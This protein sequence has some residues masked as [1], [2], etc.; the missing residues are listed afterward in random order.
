M[1]TV[2]ITHRALGPLGAAALGLALA[3][4]KT[5]SLL[6]V[7]DQDVVRPSAVSDSTSLPVFLAGR[8]RVRPVRRE[9]LRRRAVQLSRR[10]E[11]H[12]L[13][14][15][16]DDRADAPERA[17]QVRLGARAH[18]ALA[19]PARAGAGGARPRAARPRPLRRGG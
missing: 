2:R 1:G 17:R 9:L 16:A 12:H 15:A 6:R 3:G 10:P 4:C 14:A 7:T 18:R 8:L 19:G 11:P 5:D 13:R